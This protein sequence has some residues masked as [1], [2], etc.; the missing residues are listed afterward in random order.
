MKNINKITVVVN[1]RFHAFDYAEELH[2]LGLLD[3]LIST[4]PYFVAKKF[5]IPKNKYVGLS[6]FEF[7]K[8]FFRKV[9]KVSLP[10]LQYSRFFT[11]VANL[12]IPKNTDVIISFAGYSKDIFSSK[13]NLNKIKILDRGSTHTLSNKSL[14]K[15]AADY[16][17]ID[18]YPHTKK[19][20]DREILEYKLADFIML[21]STFVKKTFIENGVKESKLFVN[22]YAFSTKKFPI[23]DEK[24]F[25]MK[26][27][28]TILYVGQL[29]SRKGTK[30]LVDAFLNVKK[31]IPNAKLWLVGALTDINKSII[32]IKGVEHFGVLKKEK[33][34]EKY[35]KANVFCLPSFED[36]FGLVLIEAKY[37]NL[38]IIASKNT[39]INDLYS[40]KDKGSFLTFDAGNCKELS[41][42]LTVLLNNADKFKNEK[43]IKDIT[44]NDFVNNILKKVNV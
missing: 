14:N 2:R 25:Y 42:K 30:V 24:K 31:Q 7:L 1:G 15:Q 35:L 27:K 11:K 22:P 13:K 9:F 5:N 33:L 16:H 8:V 6:F 44:W 18:Y 32:D 28:N 39:G 38:P 4:M 34:K 3:K 41:E 37:F 12:Y 40:E 17:N 23:V 21:P 19:F 20:I 36:G 26:E 29:S 43:V 10:T